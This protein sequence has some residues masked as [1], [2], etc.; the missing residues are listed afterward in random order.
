MAVQKS[1]QILSTSLFLK[2]LTYLRYK[3]CRWVKVIVRLTSARPSDTFSMNTC[4]SGPPGQYRSTSA[5]GNTMPRRRSLH[6]TGQALQS[7]AHEK[8]WKA[9]QNTRKKGHKIQWRKNIMCGK[10]SKNS[11]SMRRGMQDISLGKDQRNA[12]HSQSQF[13]SGKFQLDACFTLS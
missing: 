9:K 6:K 1:N 3:A 4:A 7:R 8:E 13:S 12:R 2:A 10:M 11:A 5:N